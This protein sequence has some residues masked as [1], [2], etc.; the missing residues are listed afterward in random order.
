MLLLKR[1]NDIEQYRA[2]NI[3]VLVIRHL[4]FFPFFVYILL[5]I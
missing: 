2:E 5:A 1:F 3:E 4:L